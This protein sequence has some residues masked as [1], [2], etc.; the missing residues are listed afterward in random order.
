MVFFRQRAQGFG[1]QANAV[2][3]HAQFAG[4]GMKQFPFGGDDVADVVFFEFIVIHAG[5]QGIPLHEQLDLP[6]HIADV[7]KGGLAH[8]APGHQA[9]GDFDALRCGVRLGCGVGE[10]GRQ[11]AGEGGAAE[12]VG[13]RGAGG[14]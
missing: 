13:V 6:A 8:D 2:G 14:A 3:A 4:L 5:R 1:E 10:D 11:V 12:V 9:P 7:G